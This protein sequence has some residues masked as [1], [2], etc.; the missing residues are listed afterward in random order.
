M[1]RKKKEEVKQ[2]G[3][4]IVMVGKETTEGHPWKPE[5]TLERPPVKEIGVCDICKHHDNIHFGTKERWCNTHGCN[6]QGFK[7]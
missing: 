3:H 2:E 6:C 5:P 4:P 1:G 7:C